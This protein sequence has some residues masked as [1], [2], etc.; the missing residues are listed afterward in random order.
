MIVSKTSEM[1][2]NFDKGETIALSLSYHNKT[3]IRF[4]SSV[5]TKI[6]ARN[7]LMYLQ[8]TIITILREIV[9]NAV[10]A[11]SKR[12]YFR[13]QNLDILDNDEYVQGMEGFKSFIIENQDFVADEL[14][15]SDYKVVIYLKKFESGF[16]IHVQNNVPIHPEEMNRIK[17]RIEKAKIYNDFSEVY[18]DV[19]DDTEGEG[20]GL[21]LTILFLKNTG[22]GVNSLQIS[23]NDRMT[24]T[25]LL[26]PFN[27]KPVGVMN[28]IQQQ[29]LDEVRELPTFPENILEL[30][31]LCSN[32]EV[33][34]RII[35]EKISVDPSLSVSVL[36]LSNSAAFFTRRRIGSIYEAI[37]IIGLKN[38]RAIIIAS[39]AR[40]ILDERYSSFRQV[41]EHCNKAAFYAR[42]LAQTLGYN[43]IA[44]NVYLAA[45][46]HDLGKIVLLSTSSAL[47]EWMFS[48]AQ[49]RGMRTSTV[50]EEVSIGISHSS[51]GEKIASKWNLPQYLVET[52]QWHHAPLNCGE[53][54]RDV[55]YITYLANKLC[56]IEEKKYD[57]SYLEEDVLERFNINNEK[58]FSALHLDLQKKYL[59]HNEPKKGAHG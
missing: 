12:L 31:K 36:K 11:N 54:Y 19:S 47:S 17:M 35:A 37:N 59:E 23:S 38:L 29:I 34:Y 10:K 21:V 30:E 13:F 28:K 56:S 49:N 6:L 1:A 57:F 9:A 41:W 18:C 39:S 2:S 51:I 22:I 7:N 46:L 16:S 4:I 20:L 52:I 14:K 43:K 3:I 32:P 53:N 40:S 27:L 44:Q 24:Q 48:V 8:D 15:K 50:I 42:Q 26:V 33:D 55:V 5:I 25:S 45:L 58:T